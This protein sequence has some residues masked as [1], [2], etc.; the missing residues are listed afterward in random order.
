MP[1]FTKMGV[2]SQIETLVARVEQLESIVQT[3][4]ATKLPELDGNMRRLMWNSESQAAQ[5]QEA[6]TKAV[7][8]E[9]R[10]HVL[11]Q[12]QMEMRMRLEVL[13]Q[14]VESLQSLQPSGLESQPTFQIHTLMTAQPFVQALPLVGPPGPMRC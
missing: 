12:S 7:Q 2:G 14:S 3:L 1:D 9:K 13:N 6:Q 10:Q 11:A 8:T 4:L 5:S